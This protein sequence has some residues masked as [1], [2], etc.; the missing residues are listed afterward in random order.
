MTVA[1]RKFFIAT[2]LLATLIGSA[3]PGCSVDATSPERIG[4]TEADLKLPPGDLAPIAV[5][6]EKPRPFP[7]DPQELISITAGNSHTCAMRRNGNVYCWGR[8]DFGQ[9]AKLPPKS[10]PPPLGCVDDPKCVDRPTRVATA[11]F[12]RAVRIDAGD[13]HVCA[14]DVNGKAFCWGNG[15]EGQVG[16]AGTTGFFYE[17]MV[18]SGGLSFIEISAGA[19]GSCG[20]TATGISCWGILPAGP[21]S[22]ASRSTSPTLIYSA[23]GLVPTAL[24]VGDQH[25]CAQWVSGAHRETNCWGRNFEG[26]TGAAGSQPFS[27]L[28]QGPLNLGTDASRVVTQARFTCADRPGPIGVNV[29]CWGNGTSG[30]L[31]SGVGSNTPEPQP[32]GGFSLLGFPPMALTSVTT[33]KF[34]ACALDRNGAAFCWGFGTWGQLGA[35]LNARNGADSSF[36]PVAVKGGLRF[37]ALAAG[38]KHTCGIGVDNHIYCWGSNHRGELGTQFKS[39]GPGTVTNGWVAEPVQAIDPI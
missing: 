32:V 7:L 9:A 21:V 30:Q 8:D 38:E 35:G 15:D 37:K 36:M 25:I 23:T 18:V 10:P 20:T 19:R 39:G 1:T 24:S 31:G 11:A 33:G 34:H 3:L 16:V 6:I 5:P 28:G 14:L 12:D 29:V 22:A 2:P 4:S 27:L 17:P 13:E 26:Q